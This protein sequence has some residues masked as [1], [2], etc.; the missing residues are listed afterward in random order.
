[1]LEIYQT[2]ISIIKSGITGEKV[3]IPETTD[4]EAIFKF[5]KA[6]QVG[7]IIYY[8]IENSKLS[9]PADIKEKFFNLVMKSMLVEQNQFLELE[10]LSEKFEQNQ[11]DYIPLKGCI[12]K[13][14]YPKSEMR[15]MGDMDILVRQ[16]QFD[17]ACN[18]VENLGFVQTD[19]TEN[20]TA[21]NK[22][23]VNFEIHKSLCPPDDPYYDY[24]KDNWSKAFLKEDD[25]HR[26]VFSN[27]DAFIFDFVHLVK[28]YLSG[29]VGL[30][31]FIDLWLMLT[32]IDNLNLEYIVSELEKLELKRFYYNVVATLEAWFG[33]KEATDMTNFITDITFKSGSFGTSGKRSASV[34]MKVVKKEGKGKNNIFRKIICTVFLPLSAMKTLY[35]VLEKAPILLPVMWVVRWFKTLFFKRK[36]ITKQISRIQSSTNAAVDSYASELEYVGLE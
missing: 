23:F 9:A 24:F 35:P 26:Y 13:K 2:I 22:R 4:W 32:K 29:G 36:N 14:L 12:I 33:N 5:S 16:N 10:R 15:I 19:V 3:E 1:M 17:D 30:R 31:Q 21:Y 7:P 11:I 20:V 28:H 6:H 18:V 27:E 34:A 25:K 8:G